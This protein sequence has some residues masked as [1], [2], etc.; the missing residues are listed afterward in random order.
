MVRRTPGI[1]LPI[2]L[3]FSN[4][5]VI[6]EDKILRLYINFVPVPSHVISVLSLHSQWWVM[7]FLVVSSLVVH[8]SLFMGM[9]VYVAVSLSEGRGGNLSA[10][11]LPSQRRI[12]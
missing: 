8:H 7:P 4:T 12:L 11:H 9:F 3:G 10:L 2:S 5:F 1:W 6:L